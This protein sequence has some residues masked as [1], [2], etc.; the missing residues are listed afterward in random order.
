MPLAPRAGDLTSNVCESVWLQATPAPKRCWTHLTWRLWLTGSMG[1]APNMSRRM[2]ARST[3]RVPMLACLGNVPYAVSPCAGMQ[4]SSCAGM[5]V[6]PGRSP[7]AQAH[8][9]VLVCVQEWGR[10]REASS[11]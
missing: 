2:Q 3:E 4:A 7:Q 10:L 6:V 9:S 5:R 1:S 11:P 8:S